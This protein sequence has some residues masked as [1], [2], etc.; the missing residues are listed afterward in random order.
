[1]NCFALLQKE[2]LA[3]GPVSFTEKVAFEQEMKHYEVC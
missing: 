1:M 3:K 2:P